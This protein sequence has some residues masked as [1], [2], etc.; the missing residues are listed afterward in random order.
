MRR[1]VARR[2]FGD[3]ARANF[4][5]RLEDHAYSRVK[6]ARD[7]AQHAKGVTFVAG[8]FQSTDLLLGGFEFAR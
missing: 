8:R 2:G 6:R 7:P 4:A 5:S 1:S 3:T